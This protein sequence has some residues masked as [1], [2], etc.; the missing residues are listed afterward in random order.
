MTPLPDAA[1]HA[2]LLATFLDVI[3]ASVLLYISVA[4]VLNAEGRHVGPVRAVAP[5][6]A[7]V[8]ALAQLGLGLADMIFGPSLERAIGARISGAI[9]LVV[10]VLLM[11]GAYR[12]EDTT[13]VRNLRE[14]CRARRVAEEAARRGGHRHA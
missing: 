12:R 9:C 14:F 7:F 5:L 11:R 3:A 10:A 4:V 13:L 8:G 6:L 2:L 1:T